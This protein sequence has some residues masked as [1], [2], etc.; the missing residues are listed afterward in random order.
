MISVYEKSPWVPACLKNPTRLRTD[1]HTYTHT[2]IHTHTYER[3]GFFAH[4]GGLFP[5]PYFN[6]DFLKTQIRMGIFKTTQT[7]RDFCLVGKQPMSWT[8]FSSKIDIN[9]DIKGDFV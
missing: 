2:Y 9:T 4:Q 8:F 3:Q 6:G 5:Q 7:K 1:T